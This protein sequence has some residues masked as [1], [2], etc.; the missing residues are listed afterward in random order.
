[1]AFHLLKFWGYNQILC[2]FIIFLFLLFQYSIIKN[3]I[4]NILVEVEL[5]TSPGIVQN[6]FQ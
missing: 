1:M 6:V 2:V 4:L 5:F 3:A